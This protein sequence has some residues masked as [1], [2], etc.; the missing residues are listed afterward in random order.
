MANRT[1]SSGNPLVAGGRR[2]RA[3]RFGSLAVGDGRAGVVQRRLG[4]GVSVDSG[5][6]SL[7]LVD[8]S[9]VSRRGA[10]APLSYRP[11]WL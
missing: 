9:L 1:H 8:S 10:P 5:H 7:L 2:G 11:Q 4:L 3:T 6:I